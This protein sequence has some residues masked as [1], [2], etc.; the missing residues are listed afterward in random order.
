MK[1]YGWYVNFVAIKL[2]NTLCITSLAPFL[3]CYQLHLHCSVMNHFDQGIAAEVLF[4]S[5]R[6]FLCFIL[7]V[8]FSEVID[9]TT[10]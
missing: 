8:F 7:L 1:F 3:E 6:F 5:F 4:L 10:E 9:D 2:Y